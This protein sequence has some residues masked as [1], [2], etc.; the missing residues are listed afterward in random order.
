MS[1][2]IGFLYLYFGGSG[3]GMGG[4]A[5]ILTKSIL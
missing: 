1:V 4:Q 3:K 5:M 2:F